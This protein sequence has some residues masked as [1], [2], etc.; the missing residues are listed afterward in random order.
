[1]GMWD[2]DA[3]VASF[4][5][6]YAAGFVA[7]FVV[8]FATG[9]LFRTSS[10]GVEADGTVDLGL[11]QTYFEAM[12]AVGTDGMVFAMV[13]SSVFVLMMGG[14]RKGLEA[15]VVGMM[16]AFLLGGIVT[17][18]IEQVLNE[19]FHAIASAQGNVDVSD[20]AINASMLFV[21]NLLLWANFFLEAFRG[22]GDEIE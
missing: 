18:N 6:R 10:S 3:S 2:D 1:M 17:M 14:L 16:G 13:V 20:R 11:P 8:L 15:G 7:F 5:V 4:L 21:G 9:W 22:G 12:H 19:N